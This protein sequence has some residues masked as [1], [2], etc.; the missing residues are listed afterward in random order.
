MQTAVPPDLAVVMR[1]VVAVVGGRW[2][3]GRCG[4][5]TVGCGLCD[6]GTRRVYVPWK[7][8][9]WWWSRWST[10]AIE[11]GCGCLWPSVDS[12]LVLS[13]LCALIVGDLPLLGVVVV[14]DRRVIADGQTTDNSSKKQMCGCGCFFE[15]SELHRSSISV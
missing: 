13:V 6:D 4:L 11:G 3:A 14:D 2:P 12:C 9:W 5:W 1:A 8:P 15:L 10:I 7:S